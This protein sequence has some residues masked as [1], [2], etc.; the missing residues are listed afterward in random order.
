MPCRDPV[1]EPEPDPERQPQPKPFTQADRSPDCV[2]DPRPSDR[3][4][5]RDANSDADNFPNRDHTVIDADRATAKPE[6]GAIRER[7]TPIRRCAGTASQQAN[8]RATCP[9]TG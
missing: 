4:A 2:A 8:R 9:A 3:A 7:V 1:A 6:R 5:D